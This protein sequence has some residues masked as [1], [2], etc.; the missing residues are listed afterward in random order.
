MSNGSEEN[1]VTRIHRHRRFAAL[2][3]ALG[4]VAALHVAVAEEPPEQCKSDVRVDYVG[5]DDFG[6]GKKLH[7]EVEIGSPATCARVEYDLVIEQR[8]PNNQVHRVR[9]TR[10][11][12]VRDGELTQLVDHVVRPG[13]EMLDYEI[14]A[15]S[16]VPCGAE[17]PDEGR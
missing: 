17:A 4:C 16:C 3:L 6:D 11:T 7:F 12:R 8:E 15:V 5:A 13:Y 1:I 10:V 2:V 14:R 9:L